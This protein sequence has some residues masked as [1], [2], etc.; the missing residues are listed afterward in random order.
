MDYIKV[1]EHLLKSYRE[2]RASLEVTLAS[3]GVASFEQ[4]Q[5]VVGEIS[6]LRSAEQEILDLQKT[7]EKEIDD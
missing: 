7:M 4:Y 2:R 6:G 5:R 3:G 1:V